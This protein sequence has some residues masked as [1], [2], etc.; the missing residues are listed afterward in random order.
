MPKR[1]PKPRGGRGRAAKDKPDTSPYSD[2]S[3]LPK[4]TEDRLLRS[5]LKARLETAS[6]ST[7][8]AELEKYAKRAKRSE[9]R[10]VLSTLLADDA[11]SVKDAL[12]FATAEKVNQERL[13]APP[14]IK[15]EIPVPK[16]FDP[17]TK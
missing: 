1:T 3:G 14:T 12:D 11:K 5:V 15:I 4:S 10:K 8:R 6:R 9:K 17:E 7:A 16:P 13:D 2:E